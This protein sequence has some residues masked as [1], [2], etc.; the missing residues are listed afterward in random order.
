MPLQRRKQSRVIL[1]ARTG[2][3]HH[4]AI[5]AAERSLVTAE[6]FARDPFQP[7]ARHGGL[8]DPAGHGQAQARVS[9]LVGSGQHGEMAVAGFAGLGEDAGKGVSAGQ[10]GATR[11]AGVAGRGVQGA[12]RARPLARRAFRT[13]RPPLVAIRARKPWVR[14]RWMMLGWNVRFMA[15]P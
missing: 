8:G 13:R 14:L 1:L 12:K 11:K 7:V 4:H 15:I 9:Q 3:A 2:S 5:Q 6:A 10:P